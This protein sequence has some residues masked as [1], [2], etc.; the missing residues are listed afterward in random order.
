VEKG[1]GSENFLNA[2][3]ISPLE[4]TDFNDDNSILEG[5]IISRPRDKFYSVRT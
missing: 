3:F 1:K 5:E 4:S 2:L